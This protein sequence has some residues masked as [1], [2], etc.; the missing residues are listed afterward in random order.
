MASVLAKAD[1]ESF[2][3]ELASSST[4]IAPLMKGGQ[5]RFDAYSPADELVLDYETT[6]MPPK[7][8][9]LPHGACLMEYG[10]RKKPTVPVEADKFTVFMNHVDAEA[11]SILDEAYSGRFKDNPYLGRRASSTVV[12]VSSAREMLNGF[13]HVLDLRY[14]RGFDLMMLDGGDYYELKP[15]T[16]K[17]RRLMKSRLIGKGKAV[18]PETEWTAGKLDLKRIGAFLDLG[19]EQG[20]WKEIAKEC[21]ACGVCAYVCPV[22]HCFDV[23][24]RSVL[25]G[26]GCRQRCWDSCMLADFAQVAGGV[27]FRGKR[28]ERIHNWYHHKFARAVTERSRPD[29]VGCGRCITYCPAKIRIYD[30]IK[31]CEMQG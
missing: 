5:V 16:V 26:R 6:T 3:R 1:A 15:A 7:G 30:R 24:D 20:L 28:H 12:A 11:L 25:G 2:V 17:G 22:C 9:F 27:N 13:S 8:L 19:P 10:G 4:V 31:E 21:F 23:E 14:K 18:K 29:C